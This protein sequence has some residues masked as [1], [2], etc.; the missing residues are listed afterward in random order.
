MLPG[1]DQ[2]FPTQPPPEEAAYCQTTQLRQ[3]LRHFLLADERR[4]PH[5]DTFAQPSYQVAK[6]ES[7]FDKIL[8]S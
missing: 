2:R 7:S 1:I 3:T 8:R 4:V 6:N 5:L